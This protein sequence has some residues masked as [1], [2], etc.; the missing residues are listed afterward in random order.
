MGCGLGKILWRELLKHAKQIGGSKL[1]IVADPNA[2]GFY[3]KQGAVRV[4][5]I[6]SQSIAGRQLPLLEFCF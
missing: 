2:E 4:A 3:L 6:P 5:E 1:T